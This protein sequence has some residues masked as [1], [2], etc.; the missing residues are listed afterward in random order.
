MNPLDHVIGVN[1]ASELWGYTPGTVKNL[2]AVGKIRAK[3]IGKHWIIAK[4]QN[5]REGV[6]QMLKIKSINTDYIG[7]RM[8]YVLEDGTMLHESE[9]NGEWYQVDGQR[10]K[11]VYIGIGEADEDGDFAEYETIGFEK[12]L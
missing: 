11:P 8:D 6:A 5:P 7:S 3:K 10:Y 1:E 12:L 2:C 9:W 4:N